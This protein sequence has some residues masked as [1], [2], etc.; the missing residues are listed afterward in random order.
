MSTAHAPLTS[1]VCERIYAGV[2][3]KIIGVY[4]G[5]PVEGWTYPAIRERFGTLDYFVSERVGMPL[6]VPDDDISGS[7]VFFRALEDNLDLEAVTSPV[8]GDTWLNYLVE[9][10]T[11]IWWGGL[12]RS[13]EHTAYLRLKDGIAAPRSGSEALN[14]R[15]MAEQI[16]AQIFIDPWAMANPGDPER[17]V[18][19]AHEAA[20]VSHDGLAVDAACLLAAMEALAFVEDRIDTLLS[21]CAPL[22]HSARLTRLVETVVGQ[23]EKQ[24]DWRAVRDWIEAH[25]GYAKYPGNCPVVTNHAA[26][27]MALKLGKDDFQR[28]ISIAASAGWDTD[29]N[30]G[31]VGCLNG[32][33]LGLSGIDAG[34]DLRG[35]VADRM[36]V[37]SA[38][39]GECMSDAVR[40][41]RTIIRAATRAPELE[42]TR[43]PRFGF[44]F[45]GS[46][47]GFTLHPGAGW[48]QAA[49]Q[50]VNNGTGLEMRYR[51]L[52]PGVRA[53]ISV[54]TFADP[55][56]HGVEGTSYFE[57]VGSPSLYPTQIVRATVRAPAE[58]SLFLTFF[59]DTYGDDGIVTTVRGAPEPLRPGLSMLEWSVP[60]TGGMPVYR[61]GL[62]LTAP[63]RED[64]CVTIEQL[65]WEGAPARFVLGRA[66]ELSLQLTP[67]TTDTVW[68]RT[69]A[70]S[71][72]HFA[73]DYTTT[74]SISHT[75]DNG[76]VTTGT[77]DWCDYSVESSLVVNQNDGA[78]LV[79]RA[80]GHRRYY[81]ALLTRRAAMIVRQ[82]DGV[83]TI[84]AQHDFEHEPEQR[85]DLEFRLH[86][87]SLELMVDHA[88]R[89]AATD[90]AYRS[91]G[92]GFVVHRG[93]I[94]ADGFCVRRL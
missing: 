48:E 64:G 84:L 25:H 42:T 74:F 94:L 63:C 71:A 39:G 85:H 45:P 46:T 8:I 15:A 30:A 82:R 17:A 27:L 70:S 50:I 40:E 3:G 93:A 26:V 66:E 72:T 91:G 16:G 44:D 29:C 31:N 33:R 35:P 1:D 47:Q 20:R 90:D 67:W 10:K 51:A 41:A 32:I 80:R 23:C 36:Y 83:A 58:S 12:S 49:T 59:I 55:V 4:F 54:N 24:D 77:R 19:M 56:P 22:I 9:G 43:L 21:T 68:L 81:G 79:A 62:E 76:V 11:V 78:G 60:D 2:L 92:A 38:D 37:V 52:A 73:P 5:R 57:V 28:S 18:A 13:T 86:G 69:F 34:A 6:I 65:D 53:A 87:A 61:L 14:G 7:F 88:L 89:L 75:G